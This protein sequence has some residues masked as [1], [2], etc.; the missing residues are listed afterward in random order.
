[1]FSNCVTICKVKP[2]VEKE[3]KSTLVPHIYTEYIN[4]TWDS[5]RIWT[6]GWGPASARS[7]ASR[8]ASGRG[9]TRPPYVSLGCVSA[10]A[11][12]K[13]C[14]ATAGDAA[15]TQRS[16]W[17]KHPAERKN[18]VKTVNSTGTICKKCTKNN[19]LDKVTFKAGLPLHSYVIISTLPVDT[20][21]W[22][23]WT[24]LVWGWWWCL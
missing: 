11:K 13:H 18:E 20:P 24:V 6:C 14:S 17:R 23:S 16:P 2:V 7:P 9:H 15:Q 4:N 10:A 21:W 3:Q 22:S 8:A 5:Q 19:T 12:L 1:M